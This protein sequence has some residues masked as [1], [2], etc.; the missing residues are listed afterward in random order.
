MR[1]S[2]TAA[3]ILTRIEKDSPYPPYSRQ[4]W[5]DKAIVFG[6]FGVTGKPDLSA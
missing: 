2:L 4:W 6:V 3:R 1:L 5:T